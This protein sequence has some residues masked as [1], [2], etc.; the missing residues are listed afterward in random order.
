[1]VVYLAGPIDLVN[2]DFQN[3][4]EEC[5]KVFN[6]RGITCVDPAGTFAYARSKNERDRKE[7]SRKLIKINENNLLQS[8]F[9]LIVLSRS[10]SSIGTPIELNF[11]RENGIPHVVFFDGDPNGMLPAY[12]EGLADTVKYTLDGTMEYVINWVQDELNEITI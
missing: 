12:I 5:K 1:M 8:D 4:K 11:C 2:K 7:T 3:W 10:A 9:A 6:K